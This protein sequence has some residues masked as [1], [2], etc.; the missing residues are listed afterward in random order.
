MAEKITSIMVNNG[1]YGMTGGQ[2]SPCTL[3]GHK[4]TTAPFGREE[5]THG[6]PLK[7]CEMLAQLNGP[8]YIAR[9][10]ATT[11]PGIKKRQRRSY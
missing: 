2:M 3:M 6:F 5:A 11:I 1:I 7:V 10:D 8:A 9:T 4:A